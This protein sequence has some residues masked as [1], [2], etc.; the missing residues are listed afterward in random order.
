MIEIRNISKTFYMK[1]NEIHAVDDVS[2]KI[3]F[4]CK[5]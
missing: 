3:A 4:T 5:S 1:D 2:L